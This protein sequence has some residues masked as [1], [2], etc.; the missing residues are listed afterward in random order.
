MK[1]AS[2]LGCV[3]LVTA[4]LL[5]GC[6]GD[7]S[8][9]KSSVTTARTAPALSSFSSVPGQFMAKMY[10]EFLGRAPDAESWQSAVAYF[11]AN[12]CSTGTLETWGSS[13][14][15]SAEY[16]SLA[17][18]D[19][20]H[21]L[22]L[23]RGI[24]NREPQAGE[25]AQT[26]S[27]LDA[28]ISVADEAREFFDTSEFNS[29]V[30]YICSGKS[31]SFGTLGT[32][33]AIRVPTT[34]AGGYDNVTENQ[35]QSVLAS[36]PPGSTV[37]LMQK[38]VVYLTA[39]LVIPNGITLATYGN[40]PPSHHSLMARLV[41]QSGFASPMIR[42]SASAAS[43]S[44]ALRNVWVDG[45]RNSA[46][47]YVMD[48]IDVEIYG[49][50]GIVIDSN[51]LSNTLGWSTLH[52]YGALD[53]SD[54]CASNTITHNLI[55]A[56]SSG[57][58]ALNGTPQWADG[59]SI[60]CENS[61]V[62]SN[63]IIDATDAAIVVYNAYP[64][65]QRSLVR[66]N[67]IVAAGN[68][69]YAGLAFDPLNRTASGDF[70]AA[71]IDDNT[72]WSSPEQHILIGIAVGTLPWFSNG[73]IAT[74]ATV[75]DNGTAGITMNVAEG[76]TVSGMLN[77]TVQDNSLITQAIPQLW[78]TCPVNAGITAAV[79]AGDAS[80]AIQ[81]PYRDQAVIGCVSDSSGW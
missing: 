56:Y 30:P 61:D 54:G 59:L 27:Q 38:S 44:G 18:D 41:R 72:L 6:V 65:T 40:P 20:A 5:S 55:T 79:S 46:S 71:R 81:E 21:S 12:G 25:F 11:A 36:A 70:S 29:L 9:T 42:L 2:G 76:V 39:P 45:Q 57:H 77:A 80:G 75:R 50:S 69:A 47:S 66:N 34:G 17:Y 23:Y 31:Y 67:L 33:L 35:L 52:S 51:Y 28:G 49:G 15:A 3:L 26:Q 1:F 22:N 19:V 8:G 60:G 63:E 78:T 58:Y 73:A 14:V 13:I 64:A 53:L 4:A 16:Q 10:T 43:D 7:P 48:A 68:S 62:E 37:Y 32:G 24:L 74:G